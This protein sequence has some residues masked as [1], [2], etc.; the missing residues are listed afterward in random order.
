[1]FTEILNPFL[2]VRNKI[3]NKNGE[4]V[5]ESKPKETL[6][7]ADDYFVDIAGDFEVVLINEPNR[8]V[9]VDNIV[10]YSSANP[11]LTLG[12]PPV[13][14]YNSNLLYTISSGGRHFASMDRIKDHG[15]EYFDYESLAE[16]QGKITLKRPIILPEG[17]ELKIRNRAEDAQ[18]DGSVTYKVV[19]RV[20]EE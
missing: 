2:N 16:E 10:V 11:F 19:Y 18:R 15:S 13:Y 3:K 14:N 4:W 9:I 8:K 5:D 1:M 17:A 12:Q 20:I 7:T 6:H